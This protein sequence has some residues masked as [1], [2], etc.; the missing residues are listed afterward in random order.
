MWELPFKYLEQQ[1]G[2]GRERER[3]IPLVQKVI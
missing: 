1:G 3:E 2:G